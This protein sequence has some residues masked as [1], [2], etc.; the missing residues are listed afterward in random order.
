MR[1]FL[2]FL[3][4]EKYVYYKVSIDGSGLQENKSP[5]EAAPFLRQDIYFWSLYSGSLAHHIS[6]NTCV[7]ILLREVTARINT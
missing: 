4:D 2:V 1:F 7:L 5:Q 6:S 3:V